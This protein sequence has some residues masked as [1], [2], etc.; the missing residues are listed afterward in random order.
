[1]PA[2][3]SVRRLRTGAILLLAIAVAWTLCGFLA[4]PRILRHVAVN[5]VRE[6][7]H[8]ELGIGAIHFNPLRLELVID[9]LKLPDARG[10]TLIGLHRLDVVAALWRSLALRGGVLSRLE[11]D[12]LDVQATIGA[13]GHLNLADLAQLAG[14]DTGAKQ[15][16]DSGPVRFAVDHLALTAGRLGFRELDRP[17][18]F[19]A[20]LEPVSFEL[21]HFSTVGTTGND[22]HFTARSDAG[23]T[24]DWRG[25]FFLD[26]LRSDGQFQ[27]GALQATTLARYLGDTLPFAVSSGHVDLAGHYGLVAGSGPLQLT[28]AVD[29]LDLQDTGLKPRDA[30]EDYIHVGHLRV[31]DAQADV[32]RRDAVIGRVALEATQLKVWRDAAGALNL[33]ALAG[34]PHAAAPGTS[35]STGTTAAPQPD[36]APARPWTWRVTDIAVSGLDVAAEDRAV[37]PA[38]RLA[39]H[40]FTA[41]VQGLSQDDAQPLTIGLSLRVDAAGQITSQGELQRHTLAY[42]GKLGIKD[43]D[44]TP[45]QPYLQQGT[46]MTLLSGRLGAA[47]DVENSARGAGVRGDVELRDVRA[48]DNVLKQDFLKWARLAAHGMEYRASPQRLRIR[49]VLAEGAYARVIVGG[50]RTLNISHVLHPRGEAPAP[51]DGDAVAAP[52]SAPA[53]AATRTAARATPATTPATAKPAAP[54]DLGI[55]IVRISKSSANFSD[56]WIK[57]N[58]SVGI[59]DLGGTIKGLSSQADARATV[60]LKGAVDRYAPVVIS[61]Q[62]NPL[63]GTVYSDV[64]MSFRNMDLTTVTPYSGHFAGYEISK[65]KMS[66]ELTYKIQDRKLDAGHHFIIDQLELGE[67]VDSP[68]AT[69]LPVRLAIALLKDR[70][71]VI[72]LSLPVTGSLDDPKFR[73]GPLVWKA[74]LNLIA[75]AATA[76]F[77]LLG[78]LF[79]GGEQVNQVGFLPGTATLDDAARQ[80]LESL[81]KALVER[82]ALRLEVPAAFSPEV[83]RPAMLRVQLDA[84]LAA[85]APKAGPDHY[86]QLIAA[87]RADA[88]SAPLPP[89]AAAFEA[90][91]RKPKDAPPSAEAVD[92]LERALL[93]RYVVG[94]EELADLGKRRAAAVQDLLFATQEVDPVRVFIVNGPPAAADAKQLRIDVVLK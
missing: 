38:A 48:I 71:G 17:Q 30:A 5:T 65:G 93:D 91:K 8:R 4:V 7:M 2:S 6:R 35:T 23:E 64:A 43:L 70:H 73:V 94:D 82:P 28:A 18:P 88:G 46:D 78:S 36:G 92:E 32:A 26:P 13:D 33:A 44:L 79:G 3:A 25:H 77:A 81:R 11:I 41:Q 61:G 1:M 34:P 21:Q 24:L 86:R 10:N 14:P 60:D 55:D 9:D 22:Y 39:V 15:P 58:F 63:A 75:K 57:P 85:V 49:E 31:S 42:K 83:D 87:W 59:L 53:P 16:P 52:A 45:V 76:P 66:A 69:G 20:Q 19:A 62:I 56:L 54:F 68:D 47:L 12:G 90:D 80:R 89:L 50:D 67:R 51:E 27:I 74:I 29:Q 37:T 40:D 84:Q 72:D